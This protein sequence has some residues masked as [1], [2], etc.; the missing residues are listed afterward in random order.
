MLEH[1]G[2]TGSNLHIFT[3]IIQPPRFIAEPRD[4]RAIVI[5][6]TNTR[7]DIA[8]TDLICH[9]L[10]PTMFDAIRTF[11]MLQQVVV[12]RVGLLVLSTQD[13]SVL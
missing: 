5:R 4:R 3:Y 6:V 12:G 9:S 2:Y 11:E 13:N 7:Y 10:S 8:L 1:P